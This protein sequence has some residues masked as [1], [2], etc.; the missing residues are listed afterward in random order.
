MT[1]NNEGCK[2]Y[3]IV[4]L[5]DGEVVRADSMHNEVQSDI[6][7]DTWDYG[8]SKEHQ[9][10]ENTACENYG[11]I[12]LREGHMTGDCQAQFYQNGNSSF[13]F[14]KKITFHYSIFTFLV[15]TMDMAVI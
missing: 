4:L 3:L 6:I 5:P 8:T 2:K 14:K 15:I 10:Y 11:N 9:L 7:T 1:L 12:V 13:F